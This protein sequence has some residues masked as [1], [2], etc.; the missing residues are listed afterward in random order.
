[1]KQTFL[2]TRLIRLTEKV[3]L[4]S[5]RTWSGI[6]ITVQFEYKIWNIF[7]GFR[8]YAALRPEWQMARIERSK[9]IVLV[10]FPCWIMDSN[11]ISTGL[12]CFFRKHHAVY[13]I[14]WI[15]TYWYYWKVLFFSK[16]KIYWI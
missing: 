2:T 14:N 4:L 12:S 15:I 6:Q 13:F 8:I 7:P 1:V 16:C 9:I 10:R 5:S 11:D 3:F